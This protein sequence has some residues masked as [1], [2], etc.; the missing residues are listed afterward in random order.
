MSS[1]YAGKKAVKL[2]AL[3]LN[4]SC[5]E[6]SFLTE[7]LNFLSS[8]YIIKKKLGKTPGG[9]NVTSISSKSAAIA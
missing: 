2:I 5:L 4:K 1:H 9:Q 6:K 7:E 8:E 3:P